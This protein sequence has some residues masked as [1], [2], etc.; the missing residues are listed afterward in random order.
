MAKRNDGV[1]R[2]ADL[3]QPVGGLLSLASRTTCSICMA[4]HLF[5][6][7]RYAYRW[8]AAVLPRKFFCRFR[9]RLLA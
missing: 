6:V 5:G 1:E 9:E 4:R 2:R 7:K 3:D 8:K